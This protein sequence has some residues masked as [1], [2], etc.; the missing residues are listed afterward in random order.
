MYLSP[1]K[2]LNRN[3]NLL[4]FWNNNYT[5]DFKGFYNKTIT[6]SEQLKQE[7]NK[8]YI[9]FCNNTANFTIGFYAL[10]LAEKDCILPQNMQPENITF[11]KNKSLY[12]ITDNEENY[13][14]FKTRDITKSGIVKNYFKDKTKTEIP[15]NKSRITFFT[16]GTTI[17]PKPVYKNLK[18]IENEIN[19]IYNLWKN[20][21][22]PNSKIV[23]TVSHQHIYG[24]LFRALLP[25]STG[26]SA[27]SNTTRT[28]EELEIA[29]EKN[30]E[31]ILISSPAFLKTLGENINLYNFKNTPK[32]IFS[33]GGALPEDTAKNIYNLF[34]QY[35]IEIIGSTETG[36]I[37]YRTQKKHNKTW[38][39]FENIEIKTGQNS[40]LLIK[41][42]Y[43]EGN[44][45][46]KTSDKVKIINNNT[47][48]HLGRVDRTVKI[49]EK[50]VSLNQIEARLQEHKF[51]EKCKAAVIEKKR[52]KIAILAELT[53][54]G[55][56]YITQNDKIKLNRLLKT[57]LLQFFEPV[58]LPKMWRYTDEIPVNSQGKTL[59][60]DV[61]K[62]FEE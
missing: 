45:F 59:Y 61:I 4:L 17:E 41:S 6:L 33:S 30:D 36:G 46:L 43:I 12:L 42:P 26:I 60:N 54:Q 32:I 20:H 9:L 50:R 47:F 29:L 19:S 11:L 39:V 37:G 25:I 27:C 62:Y 13:I 14:D 15:N 53:T 1:S 21:F 16:S 38:C 10:L 5:I 3:E 52:T 51:I 55:K 34:K 31:I 2:I 24:M 28:P 23:S 48:I 49:E 7:N 18:L 8:E 56:E 44:T 22:S 57:H 58:T 40:E 35:P